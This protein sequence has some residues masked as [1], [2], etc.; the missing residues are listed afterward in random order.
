MKL[1]LFEENEYFKKAY[2][3]KC[4]DY[5][6]LRT[7]YFGINWYKEFNEW[8][9]YLLMG[10]TFY[11]FSSCGFTKGNRDKIEDITNEEYGGK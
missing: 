11:R 6:V 4:Y 3:N 5:I 8:F 7:K 9:L 10:N 2:P 1:T